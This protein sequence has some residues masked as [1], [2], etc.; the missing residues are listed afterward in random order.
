MTVQ[1]SYQYITAIAC[2][3]RDAQSSKAINSVSFCWCYCEF[4]VPTCAFRVLQAVAWAPDG[5]WLASAGESQ[6][7][8][9]LRS[10]GQVS[11][12]LTSLTS[13]PLLAEVAPLPHIRANSWCPLKRPRWQL[14]AL[15]RRCGPRPAWPGRRGPELLCFAALPCNAPIV[16]EFHRACYYEMQQTDLQ[17]HAERVES[18]EPEV[19]PHVCPNWGPVWHRPG[20]NM[21]G[22]KME[23]VQTQKWLLIA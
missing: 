14:A 5:S 6:E 11:S 8:Y 2:L 3:R 19:P 12:A 16:I 10:Q 17:A 9:V 22:A 23:S 4:H 18:Q 20:G 7:A 1:Q 21:H 13:K 15:G